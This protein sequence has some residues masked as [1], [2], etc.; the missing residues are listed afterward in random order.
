[1]QQVGIII[2][3]VL[4]IARKMHN[5]KYNVYIQSIHLVS[6]LCSIFKA[7]VASNES[8]LQVNADRT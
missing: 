8:S 3:C 2:I 4:L 5:I 1:M 6:R 7:L